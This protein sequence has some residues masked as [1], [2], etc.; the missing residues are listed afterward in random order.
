VTIAI[1]TLAG[2]EP[3][4]AV[5]LG[6]AMLGFQVSIGA[7]NDL[8]DAP[9]DARQK[10]GKP[11]PR[12]LVGRPAAAAV[13]IAG[14]V[15]GVALS[16]M[17]GLATAVIGLAGAALGYTYDLRLSR[18]VFS[19]LPLSLALP[20]LP[21]HAWLGATGTFPAGLATL[22]PVGVLAGGGLALA[23]GLVDLERDARSA[24]GAAAAALGR[25]GAWL[26]QTAA[27]GIAAILA[28]LLAPSLPA[29]SSRAADL[30]AFRVLRIGGIAIGVALIALGAAC[31]AANRP[32]IRER[33]W[34]LEAVGVGGVGL[35]WLAGTA[36][37][38]L[39]TPG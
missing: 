38:A 29:A 12:G 21:I 35:G 33:G 15:A 5:R 8:V 11:I 20:L 28:V 26:A 23:N 39:G 25:R 3:A 4:T 7:L 24:R 1:T 16:A 10:A 13:V 31:L 30:E 6:F 9:E 22:V 19:W 2:A 18:S 14:G 34:E 32:G 37:V 17:S 36:A 27:L